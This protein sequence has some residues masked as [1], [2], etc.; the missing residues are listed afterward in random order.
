MEGRGTPGI[1]PVETRSVEISGGSIDLSKIE[2][3][4]MFGKLEVSRHDDE[5]IPDL[6][7]SEDEEKNKKDNY[8]LKPKSI[9]GK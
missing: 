7:G 9:G 6:G 2:V 4:N 8:R 1:E 3:H 5:D